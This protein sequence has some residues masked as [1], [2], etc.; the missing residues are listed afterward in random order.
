MY[1]I[2]VYP[3]SFIVCDEKYGYD[4][5]R[6]NFLDVADKLTDEDE[7]EIVTRMV[8]TF[9]SYMEEQYGKD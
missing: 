9:K 8:K 4:Y 2:S 6:I 7:Y 5:F 3:D 1:D